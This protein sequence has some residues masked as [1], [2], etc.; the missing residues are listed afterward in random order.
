MDNP[1]YKMMINNAKAFLRENSVNENEG[2]NAFRISEVLAI[3]TGKRKEDIFAELL[4]GG[5]V[6]EPE[7][8]PLTQEI[9]ESFDL[10]SSHYKPDHDDAGKRY[11]LPSGIPLEG[12]NFC[13]GEP[14]EMDMLE[15]MSGY[16]CISTKEELEELIS[17]GYT[18]ILD[19]IE[20]ENP[21]FERE[22]YE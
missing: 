14:C 22:E 8:T 9:I 12:L 15:G 18:E 16:I 17:L 3:C 7:P 6:K 21:E 11:A 13:N 2:I 1:L 20:K 10:P 4:E 19:K 5:E